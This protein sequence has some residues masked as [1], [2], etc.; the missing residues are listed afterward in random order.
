[1]KAISDLLNGTNEEPNGLLGREVVQDT[2]LWEAG[3]FWPTG[4]GQMGSEGPSRMR[5]ALG[6]DL[7]PELLDVVLA[8]VP[9]PPHIRLVGIKPTAMPVMVR[10]FHIGPLGK[11]A[12]DRA[13]AQT[14]PLGNLFDEGAAAYPRLQAW[15]RRPKRLTG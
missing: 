3:R 1:M 7:A 12:L 4:G 6:F 13:P 11:P 10:G 8:F 2:S 5:I 9:A 14:N 15:V